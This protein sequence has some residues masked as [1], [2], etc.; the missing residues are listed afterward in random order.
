MEFPKLWHYIFT[1]YSK[2]VDKMHFVILLSANLF[3]ASHIFIQFIKNNKK[4]KSGTLS[5]EIYK[6]NFLTVIINAWIRT[7]VIYMLKG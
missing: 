1:E 6:H 5:N 4:L 3:I 7:L 2:N